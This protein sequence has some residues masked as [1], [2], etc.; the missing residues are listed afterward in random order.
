[1]KKLIAEIVFWF[2]LILKKENNFNAK[3]KEIKSLILS[4]YQP[5]E[6]DVHKDIEANNS[7]NSFTEI[8]LEQ[9]YGKSLAIDKKI[10]YIDRMFSKANNIKF[11]RK[12][13][14]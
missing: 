2:N 13:N 4:N 14:N 6:V 10:T 1:M 7:L 5:L 12:Q 11:L 8:K 9:L 3:I